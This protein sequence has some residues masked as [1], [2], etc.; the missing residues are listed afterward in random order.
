MDT[1]LRKAAILIDTLD[2]GTASA[3]LDRMGTAEAM[4]IRE[5]RK[6]LDNVSEAERRQVIR[7]FHGENSQDEVRI[8]EDFESSPALKLLPVESPDELLSAN[9]QGAANPQ[10]PF[11]FLCDAETTTLARYL[12]REESHKVAILL[13]H[14]PAERAAEILKQLPDTKRIDVVIRMAGIDE[15]TDDDVSSIENELK[16]LLD[17]EKSSTGF[18]AVL[19]IMESVDTWSRSEMMEQLKLQHS[20][21]AD[22]LNESIEIQSGG[23]SDSRDPRESSVASSHA[24]EADDQGSEDT[25]DAAEGFEF[26][27]LGQLDSHSFA[28]LVQE[29]DPDEVLLALTGAS[30]WMV[31]RLLEQ[32]P[33]REEKLLRQKMD[34]CGPL[35]LKDI[36][37]AQ[38]RLLQLT[39]Q[40][41]SEGKITPP[42]RRPFTSLV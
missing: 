3:L 23:L 17:K 6:H 7:E 24:S 20:E 1:T 41:A 38:Q 40:L 22:Q 16:E 10:K 4:G 42:T 8:A 14:L 37:V 5:A 11:E 33:Q 25:E 30:P 39:E 26:G 27:D 34:R 28:T 9:E 19:S 12:A 32:L 29:A 15:V 13:C 2:T 31:S 21:L 18:D 36:G 35:T